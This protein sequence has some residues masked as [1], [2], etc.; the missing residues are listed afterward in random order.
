MFS[1]LL[2]TIVAPSSESVTFGATSIIGSFTDPSCFRS[3]V[4][5]SPTAASASR[6]RPSREWTNTTSLPSSESA[7]AASWAVVGAD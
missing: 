5:M 1:G 7:T 6:V 2:T 3:A 4:R